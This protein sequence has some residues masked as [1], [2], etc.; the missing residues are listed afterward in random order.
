V[1]TS[2]VAD[3]TTWRVLLV[4]GELILL[5]GVEAGALGHDS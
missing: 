4:E 1:K 3:P 5:D 2:G